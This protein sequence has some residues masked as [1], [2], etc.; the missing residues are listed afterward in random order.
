MQIRIQKTEQTSQKG[1]DPCSVQRCG[2][3]GKPNA[4]LNQWELLCTPS[5]PRCLRAAKCY[6]LSEDRSNN[7]WVP[8]DPFDPPP[9]LLLSSPLNPTP[10]RS[11]S[12]SHFHHSHTRLFACVSRSLRFRCCHFC[13]A[14]FA[15]LALLGRVFAM[16]ELK[17]ITSMLLKSFDFTPVNSRF[18]TQCGHLIACFVE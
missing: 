17:T 14:R 1:T 2:A 18:R 10:T 4:G 3:A 15:F 12:F 11:V 13:V 6:T 8:F 16:N 5:Q 7:V 9:P